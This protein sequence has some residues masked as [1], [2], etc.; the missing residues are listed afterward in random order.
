MTKHFS[1]G[2]TIIV[3]TREQHPYAFDGPPLTVI[4]KKL[5]AGDYSIAGMEDRVAVERKSL[6]DFAG[7]LTNAKRRERFFAELTRMENHDLCC[8]VVEGSIA[9]ILAGRYSSSANPVSVF[10]AAVG[11][12]TDQHVPVVF[13]G[14]RQHAVAF[15]Q[16]FLLQA[17]KSLSGT[18]RRIDPAHMDALHQLV[19]LLRLDPDQTDYDTVVS[20]HIWV[21]PSKGIA[22]QWGRILRL[23]IKNEWIVLKENTS[24]EDSPLPSRLILLGPKAPR[25]EDLPLKIRTNVRQMLEKN[26]LQHTEH[27]ER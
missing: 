3:D 18:K 16:A 19:A 4:R 14:D 23:A 22:A 26:K 2:P 25:L 10:G 27:T 9:D 5:D 8:V 20:R 13:A 15:V 24:D 1:I 6:D 11:L 17:W 7:T 12:M 21:N